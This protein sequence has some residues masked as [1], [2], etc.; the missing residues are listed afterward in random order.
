MK[1]RYRPLHT[2]IVASL[3]CVSAEL[4]AV[5][6]LTVSVRDDTEISIRRYPAAGEDLLLWLA[7]E[8]GF[9]PAHE[10][11]ASRLPEENIEV[12]QASIADALF[13]PEGASSLRRLEGHYIAD[14]I[15][16][17]HELTGKRIL[18]AGDS[19][20][21]PNA[22][23]GAHRWQAREHADTYLIGAILFTPYAY[24]SIPPLGLAP[25]YLPVISATNIPIMLYQATNSG[26][27]GQLGV[28]L[29]KLRTHGSP[30]YTRMV[31]GVMSLFYDEQPNAAMVEAAESLPRSI[32]QMIP[33][34]A[35]HGVPAAPPPLAAATSSRGGLDIYLKAFAGDHEPVEIDLEDIRG[36]RVSRKDFS[37]QVTLVNFWATW[38]APCIEE[39]PSL[40]R[41]QQKMAGK[42]FELISINYAEER[43]TIEAFMRRVEVDFPVLLDSTGELARRWNVITFPSTFVIGPDGRIRYG[44]NAAIEWDDPALLRRLTD[45]I[46]R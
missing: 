15:E 21:A 36:H 34:L 12:W 46:G 5:D 14:L 39:I 45:L 8:Y 40:N 30:V 2:L 24:A 23:L 32:R 1:L 35:A 9:R 26:T 29:Q 7:P 16:R 3:L 17:A 33:L 11:L 42:Q 44:V 22:L 31:P 25:E 4:P 28:L 27:T 13:L 41:L 43:P 37:G 20:A 18:I 6:D 19:Y 10:R 38:C